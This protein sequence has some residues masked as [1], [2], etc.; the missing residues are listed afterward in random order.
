MAY[1]IS[2]RRRTSSVVPPEITLT[3]L[4]DTALT[5]LIIFMVTTPMIVENSLKIDLPQ[6]AMKESGSQVT[7]Q[8]FVVSIDHE[9]NSDR[10][11]LNGKPVTLNEL[12]A[13]IAKEAQGK[14]VWVKAGKST[15]SDT[16]IGA[17]DRI[18]YS[19]VKDVVVATRKSV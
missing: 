12:E 11:F 1:R 5:L 9:G 3:P 17:I 7:K 8:D 13:R 19:G 15:M 4:I 18:K 6:G 2:R 14:T 10:I 16:L